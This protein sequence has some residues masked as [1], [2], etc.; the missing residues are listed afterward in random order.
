MERIKI[1]APVRGMTHAVDDFGLSDEYAYALINWDTDGRK[2]RPREPVTFD[3]NQAALDTAV[4]SDAGN[5]KWPIPYI[6]TDQ[7]E[8]GRV[9]TLGVTD[10]G[11][12]GATG[13]ADP[14][15][16]NTSDTNHAF[17]PS[18]VHADMDSASGT[19]QDFSL[20]T[21]TQYPPV[22][23][24]FNDA[25]IVTLP[26]NGPVEVDHSGPTIAT[27]SFSGG[28]TA[29]KIIGCHNFKSRMYY[30]EQQSSSFW[31][32]AV[33]AAAGACSEFPLKGVSDAGGEVVGVHSLS[34]DGGSGADD[35]LCIFMNSGLMFMYQ[36]SN[37]G[38]AD[39]WALI[40]KFPMPVPLHHRCIAPVGGDLIFMS[41]IGL[42]SVLEAMGNF[43]K[44]PVSSG[45]I[46]ALNPLFRTIQSYCLGGSLYSFIGPDES[47][48][49]FSRNSGK[50]FVSLVR[51][52]AVTNARQSFLYVYDTLS[53]TWSEMGYHDWQWDDISEGLDCVFH[54]YENGHTG[55]ASIHDAFGFCDYDGD[56]EKSPVLIGAT[57]KF[58][59]ES[60]EVSGFHGYHTT[61]YQ[62][63]TGSSSRYD[64]TDPDDYDYNQHL[65]AWGRFPVQANTKLTEVQINMTLDDGEIDRI[66]FYIETEKGVEKQFEL[67]SLTAWNSEMQGISVECDSW[68][69]PIVV[70]SSRWTNPASNP[71]FLAPARAQHYLTFHGIDLIAIEGGLL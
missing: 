33:D 67:S 19:E 2:L 70:I 4:G 6:I 21:T 15:W 49:F 17:T 27:L 5:Y 13:S 25:T 9:G 31:Y 62:S 41:K 42:V 58:P 1:R 24:F 8:V 56:L 53:E 55:L 37:P 68:F 51:T 59:D 61:R 7:T 23:Q 71:D 30:W 40:G 38:D 28:I 63:A 22:Y 36:G 47:T 29:S 12:F 39:D 69:R 16:T 3:S 46:A 65:I 48:V 52:T 35:Y 57:V 50:L 60:T 34:R 32:T 54:G 11:Y 18:V 44:G 10:K 45:P 26:G 66:Q 20:A 43:G 14:T 64:D